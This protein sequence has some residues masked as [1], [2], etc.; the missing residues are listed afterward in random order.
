[1]KEKKLLFSVTK[2]DLEVQAFCTGGKG[3]QRQN[4]KKTGARII[5]KTSGARGES[6]EQ[7]SFDQNKKTAFR[8]MVDNSKF[9]LW[10]KK[11]SWE[12]LGILDEIEKEV[13]RQMTQVKVEGK[14]EKG[15][16]VKL[17]N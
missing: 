8:R 7:R 3:G 5:H 13:D 15:R 9:R 11:K 16:W 12:Y 4:K 10:L 14:D 2:K 1:M 6:R 17:D